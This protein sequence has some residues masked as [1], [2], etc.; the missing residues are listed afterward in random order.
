MVPSVSYLADEVTYLTFEENATEVLR[1]TFVPRQV[2]ADERKL[3]RSED[4]RQAG[5][6]FDS[7][8]GVLRIRHEGAHV[9]RILAS[10]ASQR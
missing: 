3:P 5:W 4:L 8:G 10:R 9:I 7:N 2:L 1:L 6:T